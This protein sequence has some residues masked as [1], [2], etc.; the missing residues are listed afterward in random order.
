MQGYRLVNEKALA[1][2]RVV[3]DISKLIVVLKLL[4]VF[5]QFDQEVKN[6]EFN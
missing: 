4:G 2:T 3:M 6:R 5:D 1:I